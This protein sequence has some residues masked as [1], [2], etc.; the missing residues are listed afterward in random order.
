AAPAQ[1][2]QRLPALAAAPRRPQGPARVG[3]A[4][5]RGP[6]HGRAAGEGSERGV[7]VAQRRGA[8]LPDPRQCPLPRWQ[9]V[10]LSWVNCPL[11][12]VVR[13]AKAPPTGLLTNG[14]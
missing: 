3:D 14:E 12:L 13:R 9:I 1:A 6:A 11:S 2:A 8:A 5:G 4:R 10:T 7:A